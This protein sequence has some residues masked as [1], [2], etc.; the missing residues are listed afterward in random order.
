MAKMLKIKTG[1]VYIDGKSYSVFTTAFQKKAKSG[2]V[3]YELRQPVFV[4]E[5]EEKQKVQT[6]SPTEA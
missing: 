2:E 6:V 4:K 3:Y 5:Y 1:E